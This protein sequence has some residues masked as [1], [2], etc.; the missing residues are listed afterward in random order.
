MSLFSIYYY[1]DSHDMCQ[2][3]SLRP[4][5]GENHFQSRGNPCGICADKVAL[6]QFF[7]SSCTWGL[8]LS[9]VLISP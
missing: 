2:A 3:V 7:F 9:G 4:L 5:I 8:P 6:G 1:L